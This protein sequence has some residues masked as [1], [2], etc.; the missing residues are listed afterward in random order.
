MM[1]ANSRLTI[2]AHI[3]AWMELDRRGGREVVTSEQIAGSVNTN[4]VVI[5]RCLGDLRKAGFVEARRGA[6]A[7]WSLVRDPESI[8]LF[9]VHQAV[10]QGPLFGMHHTPPN[11]G[12]PVGYGI[13]PA[14][15]R[16]YG[17]LEEAVRRQLAQTSVADVL[18]DVL[19]QQR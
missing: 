1:S 3:L 12:C 2:A 16:V 5:R 19:A 9:D 7:G 15:R 14:L 17:G 11:E 13:Q 10:E 8:S 4:P 18:R 6:G